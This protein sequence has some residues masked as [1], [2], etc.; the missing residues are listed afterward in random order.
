MTSKSPFCTTLCQNNETIYW[1]DWFL[2]SE[3]FRFSYFLLLVLCYVASK[4]RDRNKTFKPKKAVGAVGTN[5]HKLHATMNASMKATLGGLTDMKEAVR[6][7]PNESLNEWLAVNSAFLL[8]KLGLHVLS[9]SCTSLIVFCF[10]LV[11]L[12]PPNDSCAFLQRRKHGVWNL[13]SILHRTNLPNYVCWTKVSFKIFLA[14]RQFLIY[15][16]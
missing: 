6:C 1:F 7:P 16:L 12:P 2:F 4:F 8:A 10:Q 5:R 15:F 14:Y 13:L 3:Q 11:F 9:F